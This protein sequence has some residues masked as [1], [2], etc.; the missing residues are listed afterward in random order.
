MKVLLTGGTGMIG[1]LI[2]QHCLEAPQ[3]TEVAGLVRR[4]SRIQHSKMNEIIVPS[5][6]DLAEH[7]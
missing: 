4:P 7:I 1:G 2:L 6:F 3:V 5:F